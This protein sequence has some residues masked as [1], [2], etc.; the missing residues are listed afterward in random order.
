MIFRYTILYVKDVARSLAFY[1]QA[2][3]LTR[4]FLH[5][6]GDY[7]ELQTGATKL[8]FSSTRLMRRLGKSPARPAA[9]AP[10]FEIAFETET[11]AE[12]LEQAVRAGAQIVQ[13]VRAE[14]WGQT[15]AYVSDPDGYL[16]ELCSPVQ[17]ASAG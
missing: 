12:A 4:A 13:S 6:T 17:L 7:G 8:A 14:P 5:E 15:T 11:V 9:D 2:F 1:E 16:V 10:V 3:G